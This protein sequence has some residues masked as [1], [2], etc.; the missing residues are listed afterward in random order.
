MN[1]ETTG[2]PVPDHSFPPAAR[3]RPVGSYEVLVDPEMPRRYAEVSGDWF[4]HHF[5]LEAARATGFDRLFLHGLCT[6]A[7][8]AQGVVDLVADGDPG[9]VRR[10][11]VRFATPTFLGEQLRVSVFDAGSGAYAFEAESGGATV[12]SHGRAELR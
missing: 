9:R 7:L 6:M 8:C 10:V 12:V 2:E 1:C 3:E 4:A 5:D 11:A